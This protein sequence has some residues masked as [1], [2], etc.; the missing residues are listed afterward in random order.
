[1]LLFAVVALDRVDIALYRI[2]DLIDHRARL[3]TRS[4]LVAG[5]VALLLCGVRGSSMRAFACGVLNVIHRIL[6]LVDDLLT[7]R[8]VPGIGSPGRR[9][10]IPEQAHL[11]V[12]YVR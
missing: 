8:A 11:V 7:R 4:H 3:F 2:L 9:Q 5:H 12:R 1:V 6:H 10:L